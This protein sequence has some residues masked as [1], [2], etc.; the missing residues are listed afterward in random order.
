MLKNEKESFHKNLPLILSIIIF[1]SSIFQFI[2]KTKIV[3]FDIIYIFVKTFFCIILYILGYFFKNEKKY[4]IIITSI[5]CSMQII[6]TKNIS[7]D[8]I[9]YI[10][11]LTLIIDLSYNSIYIT[12]HYI[13]ISICIIIYINIQ[14]YTI[15]LYY[16]VLSYFLKQHK[17]QALQHESRRCLSEVKSKQVSSIEGLMED[18]RCVQNLA[19]GALEQEEISTDNLHSI[20]YAI[21]SAIDT[22]ARADHLF[23]ASVQNIFHQND[24]SYNDEPLTPQA[25]LEG[26][27]IEYVTQEFMPRKTKIPNRIEPTSDDEI[28]EISESKRRSILDAIN[29]DN[30]NIYENIDNIKLPSLRLASVVPQYLKEASNILK[31]V[32]RIWSL[33]II[34]LAN[35]T[36]DRSILAVGVTLLTPYTFIYGSKNTSKLVGFLRSLHSR[37]LRNFYH[38]ECHAADTAHSVIYLLRSMHVFDSLR[39]LSQMAIIV[40]A[41]AHDVHHPSRNNA[42]FVETN[43]HLAILYND[44]SV[45]ENFHASLTCQLLNARGKDFLSNLDSETRRHFRAKMVEV[46]LET[47]V[48]K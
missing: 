21:E 39:P 1:S 46:I 26:E 36:N 18:L 34:R 47:D 43:S 4:V 35:I 30:N 9:T 37:Y 7:I 40:G 22:A 5:I 13:A 16:V 8:E 15:L 14:F 11:I 2:K 41:L 32:G 48:S 20:L 23:D 25:A 38:N 33:D 24:D 44:R 31:M 10:F 27:V 6:F 3:P 12:F 19:I 45:L 29:N 28:D 17:H 42:F